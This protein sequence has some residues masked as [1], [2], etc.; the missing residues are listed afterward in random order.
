MPIQSTI[1]LPEV[2]PEEE[3]AL[4]QQPDAEPA[5]DHVDKQH[6]V[7]LIDDHNLARS[8]HPD[9]LSH[10]GM[11]VCREYEIDENSRAKWKEETE[12][13]LKFA[14][15]QAE[16]KQYPWPKA[17]NVIYPLITTAAIQFWAKAFP[18]IIPGQNIVK[19]M[20]WGDDDG[21][22]ATQDGDP[23][24]APL[25]DAQGQPVWLQKPGSK[26]QR[27]DR[28][29]E[30]M[31]YQ[32]LEEIP[33]WQP[34][35]SVGLMQMSVTGG[36]ARKTY[37]DHVTKKTVSRL[38]PLVNLVWNRDAP[39]F[40][41]APRHTELVSLY[42][43]QVRELELAEETFLPMTYGAEADEDGENDANDTSAPR[44]FLEQH[45]R[46]DLDGDGYPEPIIVTVHKQSSRVVRVVV[47]YEEDG[48]EE[49]DDGAIKAVKPEEYYTLYN[50]CPDPEG[51]SYPMGWGR[52][53]KPMNEAVNTTLNQMFDAGHLANTG[54]GLIGS[55]LSMSAGPMNFQI[56]QFKPVNNK[57]GSIRDNVYQFQWPGP[58]AVL[59][60][61]LGFLVTAA[62]EMAST[63]DILTDPGMATAAP[64]TMLALIQTGERVYTA[65]YKNVYNA[66]KSEFAKIYRLNRL[67]IR[68]DQRFRVADTMKM[69]RPE[70]YRLGGGVEPIADPRMVTDMQKLGRAA[71]VL[72]FKDDPLFNPIEVRRRYLEGANIE[73]IDELLLKQPPQ[74]GPNPDVMKIQLQAAELQANLGK[75][76][77]QELQAYTTAMV[78]FAKVKQTMAQPNIDWMEA[79]LNAMRLHIEALNTTIKAAQVDASVLGH[80][81]TA[82]GHTLAH[83]AH[84]IDTAQRARELANEPV[85]PG[86]A[87]GS[88][89]PGLSAVAP[90]PGN[91]GVPG[92]PEGPGG[93][94]PPNALGALGS[95]QPGP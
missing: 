15:Q 75:I 93:N 46:Y 58:N 77:A 4:E 26:R 80:H 51:G 33:E 29:G 84:M 31:S 56:G 74:Q 40:E 91:A 42:P 9:T 73:R 25:M 88:G 54:S 57:G 5:N 89:G 1:A 36:M 53:M 72:Q 86:S 37:R 90:P 23:T 43:H 70:D 64:T 38:V 60:Q 59:F 55:G 44:L 34:E 19:G 47:R 79:Q 71:V 32:L 21:T 78:N 27:A 95:A 85:E 63:Q 39:S 10:L 52:L 62:K 28:V 18:A 67:H 41:A 11:L 82:R 50:F 94:G 20:V 7:D 83:H 81:V 8:M 48:I 76:R 87:E 13:A 69:V 17:S 45:R 65:I 24:S 14:T 16:P 3:E 35:T 30:H 66:L 68:E 22:P 2:P 49:T 6:L 61:L 12:R 92:I